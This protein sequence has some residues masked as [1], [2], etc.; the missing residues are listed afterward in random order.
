MSSLVVWRLVAQRHAATAFSGEGARKYGA[1][2]SPVGLGVV[3]CSESRSLA[4]LEIVVNAR[5]GAKLVGEPWAVLAAEIPVGLVERPARVP[6]NWREHPH[7]R[8][9]QE[10]GAK[11]VREGR[12][13]V[14]RVPSV[15]VLGEFNFLLN[16]SHPDFAQVHVGQPEPFSFDPRLGV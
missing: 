13:A 4:A 3:Y 7:P 1:R 14:L 15:V 12:S 10:F 11:W 16:P 5:N 8:A 2:W 6:D 9:T